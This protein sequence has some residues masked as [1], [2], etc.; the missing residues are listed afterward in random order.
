MEDFT[1]YLI[2]ERPLD[3]EIIKG[4]IKIYKSLDFS[5]CAAPVFYNGLEGLPKDTEYE[6]EANAEKTIELY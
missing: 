5:G 1:F 4:M 3:P 6:F 2:A